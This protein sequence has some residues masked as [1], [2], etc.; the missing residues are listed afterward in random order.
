M[1]SGTANLPPYSQSSDWL[2][3]LKIHPAKKM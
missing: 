1:Q 3:A 2:Y